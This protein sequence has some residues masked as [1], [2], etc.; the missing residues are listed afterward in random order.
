MKR[1]LTRLLVFTQPEL[2]LEPEPELGLQ[3]N[4]WT[5]IAVMKSRVD[6]W[7][8]KC[9][10]EKIRNSSEAKLEGLRKSVNACLNPDCSSE[11]GEQVVEKWQEAQ[12]ALVEEQQ[13]WNRERAKYED[14]YPSAELRDLGQRVIRQ[15]TDDVALF[16]GHEVK[17]ASY[18]VVMADGQQVVDDQIPAAQLD[19][20]SATDANIAEALKSIM[21][22]HADAQDISDD[23]EEAHT[24][25]TAKM[26]RVMRSSTRGSVDTTQK[27]TD[28]DAVVT[29]RLSE[30]RRA[31]DEEKM[32]LRGLFSLNK[33]LFPEL[34]SQVGVPESIYQLECDGLE[35]DSYG[36]REP[37]ENQSSRNKLEEATRNGGSVVLK[38]YN[39]A[40]KDREKVETEI[41]R[42]HGLEHNNI[43]KIHAHFFEGSTAW[44]EM[45]CYKVGGKRLNM[46]EW[47]Q[48]SV[49]VRTRQ[50]LLLGF[51]EAVRHIHGC[52][53]S[54]NDIK[55]A[56][57]LIHGDIGSEQAILCDFEFSSSDSGVSMSTVVGGSQ[58]YV[59]PERSE[60]KMGFTNGDERDEFYRRCDMF[61]VGVVLLLCHRPEKIKIV[62]GK[63]LEK[64]RDARQ[65][66][67]RREEDPDWQT[68]DV[69]RLTQL[70]KDL[71]MDETED[72]IHKLLLKLD[73]GGAVVAGCPEIE[74]AAFFKWWFAAGHL[75]A[76]KNPQLEE[77]LLCLTCE[78]ESRFDISNTLKSA[79]ALGLSSDLPQH[80]TG[81]T[82][83][84]G[85]ISVRLTRQDHTDE[86]AA[87][88]KMLHTADPTSLGSGRD[89]GEWPNGINGQPI[90]EALRTLNLSA[91]WRLHNPDLYAKFSAG[92]ASVLRAIEGGPACCPVDIVSVDKDL[93]GTQK[94]GV[95]ERMLLHTISDVEYLHNVMLDG[96]N[97][98]YAGDANGGVFGDGTYLAEDAAKCDQCNYTSNP[99][100]NLIY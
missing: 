50:R 79:W 12:D 75:G 100:N 61:S 2:E 30:L 94:Q 36:N 21:G 4:L 7:R 52:K 76:Q 37:M 85:G 87:L 49:D 46:K 74:T 96:T 34:A 3:P 98:R 9:S 40:E 14:E 45:P 86:L 29:E 51:L 59:A 35:L 11:T 56:N 33:K 38:A 24:T 78:K 47:L 80:W 57:I 16:R 39:L 63:S 48:G 1:F 70:C 62:E 15:L 68:L 55:L 72:D 42:L 18:Q 88:Q 69:V 90:P 31:K 28:A 66:R 64:I 20:A 23:A 89:C 25:A 10:S 17:A 5:D 41:R 73:T 19:L 83:K 27:R 43:V 67:S 77:L 82:V 91:A 54:H 13:F 26:K 92:A 58:G 93:G 53:V 32:I 65:L 97:E 60:G 22:Q 81:D 84:K 95:N 6:A 44:I 99:H 8:E 71:E